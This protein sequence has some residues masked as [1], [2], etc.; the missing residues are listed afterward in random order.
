MEN[1]TQSFIHFNDV[2]D[3]LMNLGLVVSED[4]STPDAF[5]SE[6]AVRNPRLFQL[7]CESASLAKFIKDGEK[8]F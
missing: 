6:L 4:Y 7:A 3:H 1:Q 5:V 8:F 2:V